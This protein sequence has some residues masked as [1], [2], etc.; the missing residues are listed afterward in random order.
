MRELIIA[1]GLIQQ[2]DNY[3]LQLRDGDPKIGAAGLIGCFGG[4]IEDGESPA[5]AICRELAEETSLTP[6][7][8]DAEELGLVEVI[9]DHQ[10]EPVQVKG[11][12]FRIVIGEK[13]LEAKE[14]KVVTIHQSNIGERLNEM[15][16]GTRAVF[17]AFILGDS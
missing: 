10:L 3:L 11:H 13:L 8:E 5:E 1:L 15:T 7:L 12:S 16:P 9:S 14:G 2:G 4:K 17:K 6:M